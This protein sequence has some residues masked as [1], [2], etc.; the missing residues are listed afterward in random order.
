MQRADLILTPA[1]SQ[2]AY[3]LIDSGSEQKL[4]KFGDFVLVRPDPQAIWEPRHPEL[5]SAADGVYTRYA[6][7]GAWSKTENKDTGRKIPDYWVTEYAGLSFKLKTTNFKHTG[8][9]PEQ[10]VH[11]E[12]LYALIREKVDAGR[13]ISVLNMFSYTG[14]ASLACAHAGAK[15]TNVDASK[16]VNE[17]AKE[18][19]VLSGLGHAPIRYLTDNALDFLAKEIRRGVSYD[20]VIMD[21]PAFGHG[22]GKALWKIERDL[23]LLVAAV[24]NVLSDKPLYVLMNGYSAGYAPETYGNML[25]RL[26]DTKGGEVTYGGV[27]IQEM[28]SDRLLSCGMYGAVSFEKD[29]F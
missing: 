27:S 20:V 6:Q 2:G 19:A 14:G 28:H 23:T 8:L 15:V 10:R 17:W 29:M 24:T 13:E 18:N 25:A 3:A 12:K 11:W 4:E 7:H 21:P 22:I 5:W 26:A 16:Q 9:F 1:D